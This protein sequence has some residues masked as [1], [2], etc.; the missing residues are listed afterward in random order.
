MNLTHPPILGSTTMSR[1][2]ASISI[3]LITTLN[4]HRAGAVAAHE[5]Q[6]RNSQGTFESWQ[7]DLLDVREL[8]EW[9]AG[10]LKD[11]SSSHKAS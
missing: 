9:E 6:P 2:L 1:I 7:G 11:A 4:G 5:G 3:V 8:K 10:H